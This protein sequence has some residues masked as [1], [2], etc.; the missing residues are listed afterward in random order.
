MTKI[1]WALDL[2]DDGHW[3]SIDSLRENSDFSDFEITELVTF[4]SDYGLVVLDPEGLK[5]K[6]NS[7]FRKLVPQ[8]S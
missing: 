4:L 7:D 2:L 8:T 6:L 3:H 5:V 1:E